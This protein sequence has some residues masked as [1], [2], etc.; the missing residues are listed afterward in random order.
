M[1]AALVSLGRELGVYNSFESSAEWN[2]FWSSRKA[3]QY[4]WVA[5]CWGR[6]ASVP[7]LSCLSRTVGHSSRLPAI[8]RSSL[9][10]GRSGQSGRSNA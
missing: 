8:G 4:K 3:L 1:E 5:L 2:R 7:Q 9:S 6:R 10:R